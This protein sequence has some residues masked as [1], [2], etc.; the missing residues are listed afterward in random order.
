MFCDLGEERTRF[1]KRKKDKKEKKPHR[2][3]KWVSRDERVF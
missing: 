2:G 1:R 3:Q